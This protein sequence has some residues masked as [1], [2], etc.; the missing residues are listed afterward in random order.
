MA[1]DR[2][3]LRFCNQKVFEFFPKYLNFHSRLSSR[4]KEDEEETATP[5]IQTKSLSSFWID[6]FVLILAL[7]VSLRR[8][9]RLDNNRLRLRMLMLTGAGISALAQGGQQE[10]HSFSFIHIVFTSL[11]LKK[12]KAQQQEHLLETPLPDS[13]ARLDCTCFSFKF[14]FLISPF[15]LV[16]T[17]AS[18]RLPCRLDFR[19]PAAEA[20]PVQPGQGARKWQGFKC[21]AVLY[22]LIFLPSK[23]SM[24][25]PVWQTI[26]LDLWV[27]LTRRLPSTIAGYYIVCL[28]NLPVCSQKTFKVEIMKINRFQE[29]LSSSVDCP[30]CK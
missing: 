13:F 23:C 21:E 24:C 22:F 29:L 20:A 15:D 4:D 19:F 9:S 28:V 25:F 8:D 17:H 10:R 12:E 11:P 30:H 27:F 14:H 7:L 18:W 16:K 6:S 3:V 1:I 5:N 26:T 2:D